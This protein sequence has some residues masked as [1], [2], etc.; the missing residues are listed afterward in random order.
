MDTIK[1]I[2]SEVIG[3]M[4]SGRGGAF[5]DIQAAWEKASQDKESRVADFKDGCL[6]ISAKTSLRLVKL[7]LNREGLLKELQKEFPAVEKISFKVQ[8]V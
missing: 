1:N 4:S 3:R 5:A 6:T 7:N 2:V 8:S